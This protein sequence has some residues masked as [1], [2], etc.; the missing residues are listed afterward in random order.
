[1]DLTDFV[2]Y[3]RHAGLPHSTSLEDDSQIIWVESE[4]AAEVVRDG[5]RLFAAGTLPKVDVRIGAN[6]VRL[7]HILPVVFSSPLTLTLLLATFI[8]FPVTSEFMKTGMPGEWLPLFTLTNL[9]LMGGQY[10]FA[11]LAHTLEAGEWWR[12]ISPMLLHFGW[13]HLIFN[14]LWI[15]EIGRRIEQR[16]GA[17]LLLLVVIFSSAAA[18]LLQYFMYGV[19]LVGGMSGVVF[20]LLGFALVWSKRLPEKDLGVAPGIYI[21]MLV[22]LAVGFTGAIDL[23][24]LGTLANGAHLGGLLGGVLIGLG[25]SQLKQGLR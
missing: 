25:A 15:W 22:Y 23:L 12:L 13:L 14:S 10:Y 5:Y 1:V 18:N 24:G 9:T 11:N 6:S 7:R 8:C 16:N 4:Q 21:F 3:L 2:H 20:G 19:G 17:I